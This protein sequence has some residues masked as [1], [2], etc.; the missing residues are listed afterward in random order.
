MINKYF[1]AYGFIFLLVLGIL[2]SVNSKKTTAPFNN[3]PISL[4][5]P[6]SSSMLTSAPS[7][8]PAQPS[9]SITKLTIVDV[10]VGTGTPAATGNTI[11][12]NYTGM[13]LDGKVFDTSIGK[14]PFTFELGVGKVI[15]GLDQGILGMRVGGKR[16]L[17]IPPDLAY[18]EQGISGAIPPNAP[19]IFD[20]ELLDVKEASPSSIL[21]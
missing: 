4:P 12:I 8:P 6:F 9:V 21:H 19:L 2:L 18:G 3:N 13:F 17:I 5:S 11:T 10:Q 20:I 1:I 14:Q 7:A 15:P 16:R